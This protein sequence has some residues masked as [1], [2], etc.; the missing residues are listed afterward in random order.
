[1]A[2]V[3]ELQEKPEPKI[4]MA[5]YPHGNM[6]DALILDE[7]RRLSGFGQVL[8]ALSHLHAKG[9]VHRD[10]KP[11]NF[12]VEFHPYFKVVITDFGLA[13]VVID[14]VWL[15]TFCGSIKYTAPEVFPSFSRNGYRSS[16]DVWSMGVIG[17][18]WIYTTPAAPELPISKGNRE[19]PAESWNRWI[20][21]WANRLRAKLKDEDADRDELIEILSNMVEL[22]VSKRWTAIECLRRGFNTGLFKRREADGRVI[23]KYFQ[24]DLN[25][26]PETPA[27]PSP[28]VKI[29]PLQSIIDPDATIIRE[30]M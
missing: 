16:A 15:R 17:I 11:E 20:T 27:P 19:I 6:V 7:D 22:N 28:S 26:W 10:L 24:E 3:F 4:I 18:E 13:N 8:D 25:L 23:S 5:Y 9:I 30:N 2:Q 12:L 29:S 1:V 14:N 21:T